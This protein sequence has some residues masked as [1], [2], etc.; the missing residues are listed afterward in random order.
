MPVVAVIGAVAI[1]AG[2]GA[3]LAGGLAI[4][5][6]LGV[7]GAITALG[8]TLGAIGAVTGN[9]TL[10]LIGAGLGLVGGIGTLATSAGLFGDAAASGSDSLFGSAPVSYSEASAAQNAATASLTSMP[11]LTTATGTI[12]TTALDPAAE[13]SSSIAPS[14]GS[15]SA[16]ETGGQLGS[17]LG[18]SLTT[19]PTAVLTGSPT[20]ALTDPEYA[21]VVGA[22]SS[23]GTAAQRIPSLD[24]LTSQISGMPAI[25]GVPP[26]A[27]SAISPANL[28][29]PG[30]LMSW[31]HNNPL[32]AYGALQ[33]GGAFIT[34]LTNPMTPAQ[35]TALNAQANANN[36]AAALAQRQLTNIGQPMPIASVTGQPAPT[37]GLINNKPATTPL[38]TG[39]PT[40][41]LPPAGASVTG[42]PA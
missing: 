1:D 27:A 16:I 4:G 32:L 21:S 3:A 42:V 23:S 10:G 5:S 20:A 40:T 37:G 28:T 14:E 29:P 25:P 9:K 34:G 35:I 17:A 12:N 41:T 38:I 11:D 31:A 8:A 6:T 13:L 33:A 19:T 39:A 24:T 36:A 18:Q 15:A 7:L 2:F 30:G 26:V 22:G